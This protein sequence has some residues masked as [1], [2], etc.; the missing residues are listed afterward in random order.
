M[1]RLSLR[2]RI[3]LYFLVVPVGTF[4]TAG[5]LTVMDMYELAGFAARTGSC[6]VNDAARESTLALQQQVRTELQTLAEGQATICQLQ[7][8]RA[9]AGMNDLVALY[10]SIC[11]GEYRPDDRGFVAGENYNRILTDEFTYVSYPAG[12]G[13]DEIKRGLQKLTMMRNAFKFSCAYDDYYSGMGIALPNGLFFKYD[14][15]PVPPDYDARKTP[16][17][18]RAIAAEGEVVWQDPGR[19]DASNKLL[20]TYSQAVVVNGKVEAVIVI[21]ILPQT[22][23]NEFVL[24]RGTGCFAFMVSPFGG[25]GTKE[26]I[27]TKKLIWEFSDRERAEFEQAVISKITAG[28]RAFFTTMLKGERLDVAFCPMFPGKCGIGVA[29]PRK[30]LYVIT[31]K[32]AD[33]IAGEERLHIVATRNYIEEKIMIYLV[34]G[35][36]ISVF[37]L[38]T[39]G[40]AARHL[41]RP[42][43]E[44]ETGVE[45]LGKRRLNE[46]IKLTSNDEF[47]DLGE[48]F[49]TMASELNRQIR[50][51]KENI[52]QQERTRQELLVAAEIQRSLLPDVA[53][54]FSE[55]DEFDVYAEMRPFKEIGGDFYDFFF[56]GERRLFFA[57]GDVS[58]KGLPAALFM[59]RVLTL[60]RHEAGEGLAPDEIFWNVGEELEHNNESCMFFTGICGLFTI[61]TGEL[62]LSNAGHPP[63]YLRHENSFKPVELGKG[64]IVG[65]LALKREQFSVTK[66]RLSKGDTLFLY[67]DGVTEAFN[68]AGEEYQAERLYAVLQQLIGASPR[69]ILDRVAKSVSDFQQGAPQSD[70]MTMLTLKYYG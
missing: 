14:W 43:T 65:A 56:V 47:Q 38:L 6:I 13:A 7:M 52:V 63:P 4:L 58:G 23:S 22:I 31:G 53:L 40:L 39:A 15:Y 16:W 2:K 54:A 21:D 37:V 42:I 45:L 27:V 9:L 66:L 61:D 24:T 69:E 67:T 17:F 44:L 64:M 35:L 41:G 49:N 28:K 5:I 46:K 57:I 33:E 59:M 29:I 32:A 25:L 1:K 36:G 3:L 62:V 68:A 34:T 19:S 26:D 10:A 70:D 51:L 12:L 18:K 60:L 8:R 20:L 50:S 48:T 55:Y 30:K 11:N